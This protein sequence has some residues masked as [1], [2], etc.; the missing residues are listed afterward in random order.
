ME[1]IE[2]SLINVKVNQLKK[3][4]QE[5]AYANHIA[6]CKKIKKKPDK[7]EVFLNE[8]VFSKFSFKESKEGHRYW[9]TTLEEILKKEARETKK[10]YKNFKLILKRKKNIH[11]ALFFIMCFFC[12]ITF[13]IAFI[14]LLIFFK[15]L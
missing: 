2:K 11:L 9:F 12:F 3:S 14:Y 10:D 6:N 4:D 1:S 7:L 13:V 5:L 15:S 8:E